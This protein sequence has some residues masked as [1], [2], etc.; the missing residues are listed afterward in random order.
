LQQR[1]TLV[2]WLFDQS[3]SMQAQREAISKRFS[4][5]Y[6]E[7]EALG[8]TRDDA[9]LGAVMAFGQNVFFPVEEPTADAEVLKEAVLK[10]ENDPSGLENVFSAVGAAVDKY[11]S[12]RTRLPRRNVMLVIVSDESGDDADAGLERAIDACRRY[13]MPVYVVGV[14]APF[15]R[16][17]V[18]I[19]YVD[20]DPAFDQ[21]PRWLPVDQGPE[22]FMPEGILLAFSG[23]TRGDEYDRL[24]SG[25]GPY[26][27]TR[28]CYESSGIYFMVHPNRETVDR[29][30]GPAE[31][32]VMASNLSRFFDPGIMRS[33]QPDYVS[34]Q[35]Y[36]ELLRQNKARMALVMA[37]QQSQLQPMQNPT[38]EFPKAEEGEFKRMLD[39]AQQ[40]AALLDFQLAPLYNLLVEGERDREHLTQPRWKA[41]FDLAMGRVL[42]VKARTESYNAMLA[43]AKG[44]LAFQNPENDTFV[45]VPADDASINSAVEKTAAKAREHLERVL[46]EHAGTPWA[47]LAE[48]ELREPIGWRWSEKRVNLP[49]RPQGAPAPG[50]EPAPPQDQLNRL[51]KPKPAR[52][53]RL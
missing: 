37:A 11:K 44:G 6:Q 23:A 29:R 51:P 53:I 43:K 26:A 19:K 9:L 22:S 18:E 16:R 24:D 39:T 15:G 1:P 45:L 8:H 38:L 5:I 40:Q 33:Y 28:L 4:R 12:F 48:R 25:F 21:S 35:E 50:G 42:A 52:D 3:L 49:P 10:I 27:L 20:P 32:G 30:V 46:R 34:V 17:Q 2:V 41:G 7:L 31:T 13:E 14:P 36:Q 47:L